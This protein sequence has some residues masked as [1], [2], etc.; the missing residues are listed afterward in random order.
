[1]NKNCTCNLFCRKHGPTKTI[2]EYDILEIKGNTIESKE[3]LCRL[4]NDKVIQEIIRENKYDISLLEELPFDGK[5]LGKNQNNGH[6]SIINL[7]T[8]INGKYRTYHELLDT[9][10]HE[11]VHCKYLD[12]DENFTNLEN[13]FRSDYRKIG[14]RYGVIKP[15]DPSI[16]FSLSIK[17][18]CYADVSESGIM[19]MII[20]FILSCYSFICSLFCWLFYGKIE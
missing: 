2:Y 18:V 17:G 6:F 4:A 15:W 8:N 1:M 20:K 14:L 7:V 16:N 19:A 11:L 5:V 10:L 12:H 3:L 13:K 9:M